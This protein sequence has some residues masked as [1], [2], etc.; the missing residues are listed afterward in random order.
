[1]S[2]NYRLLI[3]LSL[4]VLLPL[5]LLGWLGRRA[6]RSEQ[7]QFADRYHEVRLG[8]LD[9]TATLL[10]QA[11]Q[12]MER[13]IDAKLGLTAPQGPIDTITWSRDVARSPLIRQAFVINAS[14]HS[15]GGI[16]GIK[17]AVPSPDKTGIQPPLDQS[18]LDRMASLRF[19]DQWQIVPIAPNNVEFNEV[20]TQ[21]WTPYFYGPGIELLRWHKTTD[22]HLLVADVARTALLARLLEALPTG[23]RETSLPS[24]ISSVGFLRDQSDR[25]LFQWGRDGPTP[26]DTLHVRLPL[27]A[28]LTAWHL[29]TW[30]PPMTTGSATR[31]SLGLGLGAAALV[32]AG[33]AG[34]LWRESTRE[35]RAAA[36]RISFVNHVSHE[37]RTPLTNIALYT[38]L[39]EQSLPESSDDHPNSDIQPKNHPAES[40]DAVP[41]Q[42]LRQHLDVIRREGEK[43][44]RLVENV[45]AF[46]RHERGTL[47]P[48]WV[49]CDVLSVVHEVARQYL[50]HLE[51]KGMQL[52]LHLPPS[53]VCRTDPDF[54]EQ[55]LGNLI[56]NAEKYAVSGGWVGVIVEREANHLRLAVQDRGP[57]IPA[58]AMERVF[59]PFYRLSH[60]LNDGTAGTGIGLGLARELARLLGGDLVI[61]RP[62]QAQN[63]AEAAQSPG[64]HFVIILPLTPISS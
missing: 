36:A 17:S 56:S 9:E 12:V 26:E 39:A 18:S 13:E 31:W 54:I 10:H 38:D 4:L 7:A 32:L 41:I 48:Q 33:L 61:Q 27:R 50:P 40:G 44:G 30:S 35:A 55:M 29:E 57:G 15:Q 1:V 52:E 11:L 5:C 22:G 60:G 59:E 63:S 6:L 34:L 19:E 3:C 43:L 37:F 47:A 49:E 23:R 42:P 25:L 2:L 21:G 8:Q 46:S 16:R 14:H 20:R 24:P 58:E 45:L 53:C 62:L 64:A 51:R 28:P